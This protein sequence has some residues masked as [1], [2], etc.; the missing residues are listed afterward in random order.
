MMKL[1]S[2]VTLQFLKHERLPTGGYNIVLLIPLLNLFYLINIIQIRVSEGKYAR[3][4]FSFSSFQNILKEK[5]SE[6]TSVP[7]G[8][9]KGIS[10]RYI[11]G[12][13]LAAIFFHNLL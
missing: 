4:Y 5:K 6:G 12:I 2:F 11:I 9:T 7:M 1:I 8:I 13:L 3:F 10:L